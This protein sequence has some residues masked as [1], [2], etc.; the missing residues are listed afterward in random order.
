MVRL[1]RH[2]FLVL[3]EGGFFICFF[4]LS[5]LD[6]CESMR[7]GPIRVDARHVVERTV[8]K[9]PL[10][11]LPLFLK[12]Q[13]VKSPQSQIPC[14]VWVNVDHILLF[15]RLDCET[16]NLF[17]TFSIAKIWFCTIHLDLGPFRSWKRPNEKC[18][19]CQKDWED[20]G[21]LYRWID[22]FCA[23]VRS[24]ARVCSIIFSASP[25]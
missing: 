19:F 24:F 18:L 20:E 2:R 4:F 25:V 21:C 10:S 12:C 6:D 23:F 8:S 5:H 15:K 1:P 7:S 13:S 3:C 14:Y 9:F 17:H 22:L 16:T 11:F